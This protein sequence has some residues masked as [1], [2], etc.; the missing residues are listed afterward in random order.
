MTTIK[1]LDGKVPTG[2]VQERW[3]SHKFHMKIVNAAN[4]R[5]YSVLVVGTTDKAKKIPKYMSNSKHSNK[6][7]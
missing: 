7:A 5:K 2:P 3:K 4:K 1:K 6:C